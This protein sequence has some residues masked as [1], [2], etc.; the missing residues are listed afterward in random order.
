MELRFELLL[1]IFF[2]LVVTIIGLVI[3]I[4]YN[5]WANRKHK[6]FEA[7]VLN[8]INSEFKNFVATKKNIRNNPYLS[9]KKLFI[10]KYI[11]YCQI[12][13]NK[14]ILEKINTV[15]KL[16]KIDK[17]YINQLNSFLKFRRMQAAVYLGYIQTNKAIE[18]LETR[19][20]KENKN[21]VKIHIAEALSKHKK[22]SSIPIIVNS[23]T[24]ATEYYK[25]KIFVI[26]SSFE[27]VLFEFIS[28]N[29]QSQ[30]IEMQE[31]I[32]NFAENYP[33]ENLKKH[34][35]EITNN[36]IDIK[37]AKLKNKDEVNN[38]LSLLA[39]KSLSKN[40][41][42]ELNQFHF[43]YNSNFEI[44]NIAIDS[45]SKHYSKENIYI[46]IPH[47]KEVK[48]R[49]NAI[50]A[51]SEILKYKPEFTDIIVNNF[52][53]ENVPELKLAFAQILANR[54]DYFLH[55][56]KFDKGKE[57]RRNFLIVESLISNQITSSL[58]SFLNTN[59]DKQI[60]KEIINLLKDILNPDK[61]I[62]SSYTKNI[63]DFLRNNLDKELDKRI[64]NEIELLIQQTFK[65]NADIIKIIEENINNELNQKV[66]TVVRKNLLKTEL[67][68]YLKPDILDKLN[69]PVYKPVRPKREEVVEKDK[70]R[71]LKSIH[72]LLYL[73]FPILYTFWHFNIIRDTP[74]LEQTFFYIIILVF[75]IIYT[76]QHLGFIRKMKNWE[77]FAL[78]VILLIIPLL[79][80]LVSINWI[81]LTTF[82]V[83]AQLFVLDFNYYLVF[84]SLSINLI[85][86]VL[87]IL[88]YFGLQQQV[89]YANIK[90]NTFLFKKKILPSISIIA[91]AYAE[92]ENIIESVNSQLNL[93]Y[94]D[95]EL[96]VVSDGSPDNT[97][98]VLIDYF[99]LERVDI[100][101]NEKV[102]TQPIRGVYK[103]A[104]DLPKLTVIDKVN[105]GKAD[106]LNVGINVSKNEY[107]CG[108]DSDSLLEADALIKLATMILNSEKESIA[109][110]GNI[111]PINSCKVHKG[112]LETIEV[113]KESLAAFQTIEYIRAFMSGRVGWAY[114]NSLL[115]ISGAFGLFK[116]DRV[117]EMGGYLTGKS[118]M[119]KDTVGEDME[120]VVRLNRFMLEKKLPYSI[121]YCF[122]ANC[123]TEVPELLKIQQIEK[124][125]WKEK[126]VLSFT[127]ILRTLR[128]ISELRMVNLQENLIGLLH[129]RERM[130]ILVNQRDR[131]HRGLI[132]IL[133]FHK[134]MIF[135]PRYKQI[136]VI[137]LP[138]FFI[139][140]MIG[141]LIEFQGY[142][143]VVF[144]AFLGMLNT[145]VALLLFIS[146]IMLG[147]VISLSS[148]LISE[149]ESNL[150]SGK[151]IGKLIYYAFIEN[152]GPRQVANFWRIRGFF[153][154]ME[155]PKGWGQ[156]LRKAKPVIVLGI[157]N[158]I[159]RNSVLKELEKLDCKVISCSDGNSTFANIK[160]ENLKGVILD[161][162]LP[163]MNA[164]SISKEMKNFPAKRDIPIALISNNAEYINIENNLLKQLGIYTVA[165]GSNEKNID[166]I[167]VFIKQKVKI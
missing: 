22:S 19:L 141:P 29:L 100:V 11:D 9:D 145:K 28:K 102:S 21:L 108:I 80:F 163:V 14:D 5:K 59:R 162:K 32:I 75:P 146:S 16:T 160:K 42:K 167:I 55:S 115:I 98:K 122:N 33:A 27:D 44:R 39:S 18:A 91:P 134:N 166:K 153:S 103:N 130:R 129:T 31:L 135:R 20:K 54:L 151:E 76:I 99:E 107:F 142:V 15:F 105:G 47:L 161:E 12:S 69:L 62:W 58:I 50:V 81:K 70:I 72:I 158:E 147:I 128:L 139:F 2:L 132:D 164:I 8:Y 90:K 117:I 85:Y 82:F 37:N 101:I 51:I 67:G 95:Y 61:I 41:Y 94:P 106:A 78:L 38:Y 156:M 86:I 73:F 120:L 127:K 152:F 119:K 63:V 89:K 40:Y 26:L 35:I 137:S 79:N 53:T 96:I 93:Q 1:L 109:F 88:S 4:L 17:K 7:Q 56:L 121:H 24:D 123:W 125:T 112:K 46:L 126:S 140:E 13:D 43:L 36:K 65:E 157:E 64:Y 45:I 154:S 143:M 138:Y 68:T 131:W 6:I 149:K 110:G 116:K 57:K 84:Y 104:K 118:V 87:L 133:N 83:Q 97:L 113:P 23:L 155:L 30:L 66:Q 114:I 144:A 150:F 74:F 52:D 77:L 136:G 92:E 48:T 60:E 25:N 49:K 10:L 124:K 71:L 165:E 159:F 34:L 148:L 3:G 111:L